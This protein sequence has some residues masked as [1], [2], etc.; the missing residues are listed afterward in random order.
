MVIPAN[1]RRQVMTRAAN[2]CEYCGL[3]QTGQ[4]ATFHIDHV[5]PVE[6]ETHATMRFEIEDTCI[7]ISP[8]AQSGL[9]QPFSQADGST[10]RKYG[11]TGTPHLLHYLNLPMKV[12]SAQKRI[13]K[14][15]VCIPLWPRCA[16]EQCFP[17]A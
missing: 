2:C 8:A 15:P 3:A 6:T 12:A 14:K 1:L 10:T 13:V 9:F 4:E 5:V 7:G 11:G 16:Q 17:M